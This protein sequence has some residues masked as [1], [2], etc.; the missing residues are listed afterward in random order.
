[1]SPVALPRFNFPRNWQTI[2]PS[3]VFKDLSPALVWA[4]FATLCAIPRPSKGEAR[5]REHLLGWAEALGLATLVDAAGNLIVRKPASAG[6]EG[7]PGVILQSHLDM[8]CQSNAETAHD[9]TRHPITPL[10]RDGWTSG[11]SLA[12]DTDL[13][14]HDGQYTDAQ[15]D[16][17]VGWGHSTFDRAVEFA[18]LTRARKLVVFHHDPD[19]DDVT[20]ARLMDELVARSRPSM[21]VSAG[22]EGEV[23]TL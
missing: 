7:L 11:G 17:R 16:E 5:L 10:L 13:L 9:F 19:H 1:M 8:V 4:H 6:R 22:R 3:P 21:P 12:E 23:F 14:I 20:L 18:R 2:T 15:Y